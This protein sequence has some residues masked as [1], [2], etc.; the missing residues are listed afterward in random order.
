MFRRS[1]W[2]VLGSVAVWFGLAAPG[3]GATQTSTTYC[4][5][6][7][8]FCT[9]A[10]GLVAGG[11]SAQ[12]SRS[13]GQQGLAGRQTS[14][15]FVALL[16]YQAT[17]EGFDTDRDG[18]PDNRDPDD[19]GDGL[20]DSTDARPYDT[21]NDGLNNLGQDDDDDHDGLSD[22][23]EDVITGTD[24]LDA[25]SCL[26]LLGIR[27]AGP[28]V[29]AWWQ[30]V[31]GRTNYWLQRAADLRNSTNWQTIGGPFA[32]TGTVTVA[33]DT[34]LPVRGFYRITIPY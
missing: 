32:A 33:T 16:G 22:F 24:P 13:V 29:T 3:T 20:T 6:A 15:R 27:R 12:A 9:A 31:A 30:S 19:D 17:T 7:R 23:E 5:V 28:Q 10:A 8:V 4:V 14:A 26:R 11:P 18:V 25:A 1:Y 2:P 21:D 34:N